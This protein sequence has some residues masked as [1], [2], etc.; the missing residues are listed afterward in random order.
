MHAGGYAHFPR[1]LGDGWMPAGRPD[2][3]RPGAWTADDTARLTHSAGN[4]QRSY[5]KVRGLW[6]GLAGTMDPGGRAFMRFL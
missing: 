1:R 4:H 3:K 6:A 5:R 2:D